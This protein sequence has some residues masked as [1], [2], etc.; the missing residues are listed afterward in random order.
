MAS[1]EVSGSK[2]GKCGGFFQE[3]ILYMEKYP[4]LGCCMVHVASPNP[5]TLSYTPL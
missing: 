3:K 2:Y 4:V 1:L 5:Y